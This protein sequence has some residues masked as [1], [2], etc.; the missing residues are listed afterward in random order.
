MILDGS[1]VSG[2]WATLEE[3]SGW[4]IEIDNAWRKVGSWRNLGS[5]FIERIWK[6]GRSSLSLRTALPNFHPLHFKQH[7]MRPI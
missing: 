7:E 4:I 1:P 5:I 2:L 3:E 6:M